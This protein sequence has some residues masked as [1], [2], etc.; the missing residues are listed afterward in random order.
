MVHLTQLS[1]FVIG[2][3][4]LMVGNMKIT[5][6]TAIK[7]LLSLAESRHPKMKSL[8]T[9]QEIMMVA[10]GMSK[11]ILKMVKLMVCR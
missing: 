7:R 5:F 10:K 4:L 1:N 11:K 6:S 3:S 8:P 9:L 2:R